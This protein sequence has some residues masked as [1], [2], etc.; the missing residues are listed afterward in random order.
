VAQDRDPPDAKV[1]QQGRGVGGQQL[2]LWISG[3]G[4]LPQPIWSGATTRYPAVV[5]TSMTLRK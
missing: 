1:I 2:E 4:D 5:S 3:L